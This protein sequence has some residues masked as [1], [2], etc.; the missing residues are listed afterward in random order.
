LGLE[1]V[2]DCGARTGAFAAPSLAETIIISAT[3]EL[4]TGID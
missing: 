2:S 1:S 3:V 4:R